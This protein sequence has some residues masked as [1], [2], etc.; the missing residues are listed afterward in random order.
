M[1][2]ESQGLFLSNGFRRAA[3]CE[4]S[5]PSSTVA[6]TQFQTLFSKTSRTLN[7]VDVRRPCSRVFELKALQF[8]TEKGINCSSGDRR[9]H[10]TTIH[11]Y[12]HT[13]S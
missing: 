8:A 7:C 4:R 3:R 12:I 11:T 10:I 6:R 2:A 9:Q 5:L 1:A 13:L